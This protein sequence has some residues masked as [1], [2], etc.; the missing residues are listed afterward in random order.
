MDAAK[1]VAGGIVEQWKNQ[2]PANAQTENEVDNGRQNEFRGIL[3]YRARPLNGTWATAPFLH[4]GSVPSLY[5][6]LLPPVQRPKIFYVGSWEFDPVHV[7]VQTGSPFAGAFTFDTRLPGNANAGHEYGTNLSEPDR[8]ALLE[9][10]K[11]L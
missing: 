5:D 4:N 6:L 3:A 2:S 10:L 1:A 7:G 8:M 9:F 11:T